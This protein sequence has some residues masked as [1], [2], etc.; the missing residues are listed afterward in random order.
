MYE[1]SAKND[2]LKQVNMMRGKNAQRILAIHR[3]YDLEFLFLP[4]QQ[5]FNPVPLQFFIICYQN[6]QHL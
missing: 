6:R 4:F 3:F 1:L 2:R 5:E